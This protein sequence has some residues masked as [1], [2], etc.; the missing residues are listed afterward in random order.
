MLEKQTNRGA[1]GFHLPK[2]EENHD[3]EK[4]VHL[5]SNIGDLPLEN[6]FGMVQGEN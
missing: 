2:K 1:G 3:Q 6:Q 4:K 5:Q